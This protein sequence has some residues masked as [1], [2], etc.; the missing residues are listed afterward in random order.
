MKLIID[1]IRVNLNLPVKIGAKSE[2]ELA[3]RMVD[4][5]RKY[6]MQ[7]AIHSMRLDGGDIRCLSHLK[8]PAEFLYPV[9]WT[10]SHYWHATTSI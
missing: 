5:D 4:G 9:G 10:Q 3:L 7:A 6:A 8:I 2:A 1:Q